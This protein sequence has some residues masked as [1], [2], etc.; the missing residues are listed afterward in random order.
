MKIRLY[1]FSEFKASFLSY[2]FKYRTLVIVFIP[3]GIAVISSKNSLCHINSL[4]LS[5]ISV[6]YLFLYLK[7]LDE[8]KSGIFDYK[9]TLSFNRFAMMI[10]DL[11]IEII[12][13]IKISIFFVIGSIFFA[14][15][16]SFSIFYFFA[17][18]ITLAIY[19]VLSFNAFTLNVG[20][21]KFLTILVRLFFITVGVGL[22]CVL[23]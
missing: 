6:G 2:F 5:F 15:S 19:M 4:Y 21:I 16:H 12:F 11:I 22:F 3:M 10:C 14:K 1:F 20:K 17:P 9:I 8:K 13:L 23:L 18:Y 7:S